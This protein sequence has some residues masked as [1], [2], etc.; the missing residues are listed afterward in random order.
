MKKHILLALQSF[1]KLNYHTLFLPL[2]MFFN[3]SHSTQIQTMADCAVA[4]WHKNSALQLY[5]GNSL[6]E[7]SDVVEERHSSSTNV[8]HMACA[9]CC[10]ELIDSQQTL[11][12]PCLT[13]SVLITPPA[14]ALT[15]LDWKKSESGTEDLGSR[16]GGTRMQDAL[17]DM[18]KQRYYTVSAPGRV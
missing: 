15:D 16:Q 7:D 18:T 12:F 1:G 2:A 14:V 5:T 10:S 3:H 8:Q 9:G 13:Y 6:L 4:K 11:R 17:W